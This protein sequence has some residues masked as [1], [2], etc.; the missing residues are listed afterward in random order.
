VKQIIGISGKLCNLEIFR[1]KILYLS[2][3]PVQ[4]LP[5]TAEKEIGL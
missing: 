5:Q 2:E 4:I 3:T 1:S